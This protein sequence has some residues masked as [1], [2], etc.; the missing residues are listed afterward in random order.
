MYVHV[1]I[2][3]VYM[4]T[5][6]RGANVVGDKSGITRRKS[7]SGFSFRELMSYFKTYSICVAVC[8]SVLQSVAGSS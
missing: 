8:C 1:Y 7:A 5:A 3:M 6:E 2:Y 4:Y